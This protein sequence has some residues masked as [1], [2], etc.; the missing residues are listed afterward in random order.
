MKRLPGFFTVIFLAFFTVQCVAQV[1]IPGNPEITLEDIK[2]HI[3]LIEFTLQTRLTTAQK[4]MYLEAFKN[5]EGE[6]DLEEKQDFLH[7]RRLQQS[8][9]GMKPKQLEN[10]RSA[11]QDDFDTIFTEYPDDPVSQ[12]FLAVEVQASKV[13]ASSTYG[14]LTLQSIAAF[15]EW[16]GFVLNEEK[17]REFSIEEITEI[18]K[19]LTENFSM[20]SPERQEA[21]SR[22]DL[23]W[24][25]IKGAWKLSD[26]T[27]KG[28]W[29]RT[30]K[31][32]WK[33]PA[34]SI[35]PPES[36]ADFIAHELWAGMLLY[37]SERGGISYDPSVVPTVNIW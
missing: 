18:Q 24:H 13:T 26:D 35:I 37:A 25:C 21:L 27:R 8:L 3:A 34:D 32:I 17:P 2:A 22:F 15:A 16:M 6:M 7:G 20:L 30:I 12:L 19:Y 33:T 4:E 29:R 5:E 14:L 31:S 36:I 28:Q 11:L 1:I 9:H 23:K 10:V